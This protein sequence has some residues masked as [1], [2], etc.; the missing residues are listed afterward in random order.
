M[1]PILHQRSTAKDEILES[2]ISCLTKIDSGQYFSLHLNQNQS[3]QRSIVSSFQT[4]V[5]KNLSNTLQKVKWST[6][7]SPNKSSRDSVDIFGE[8]D[9]FVIVIELDK[10]RADQVAKKFVSRT[11]LFPN[12]KIYYI[13]LC[14]PGT[15]K[16]NKAECIKYFGYCSTLAQKMNNEYAGFIIE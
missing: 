4:E 9:H 13:S 7:Y 2:I 11:A 8:G 5:A 6:E 14:Y 15:E 3:N 10:N 16:M 1:K 12:I